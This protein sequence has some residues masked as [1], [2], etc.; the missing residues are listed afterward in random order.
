M[1]LGDASHTVYMID[2]GLAK[3]YFDRVAKRHIPF[4]SDKNLTGT[5]RYA[6]LSAHAGCEQSRR[7]DLEALGYVLVYLLRGALP[8]QG[9]EGKTK[10][11]KYARIHECKKTTPLQTLCEEL[12][13]AFCAYLQYVRSL[14]FEEVPDYSSLRRL[15]RDLWQER[16]LSD[17]GQPS[18]YD[19]DNLQKKEKEE[20]EEQEADHVDD[21]ED[22]DEGKQ[23]EQKE[24]DSVE[25]GTSTMSL[26]PSTPSSSVATSAPSV[27][28]SIPIASKF[29]RK[30]K[31]LKIL[32]FAV[33]AWPESF[34]PCAGKA[35]TIALQKTPKKSATA[36]IAST[37]C[38][39]AERATLLLQ[40]AT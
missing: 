24:E 20:K 25:Q 3:K 9:L 2:L 7:D 18:G 22:D 19:W 32:L 1:G 10:E 23:K 30:S 16:H 27:D 31:K 5:A 40:S 34:S 33:L 13:Q 12:P 17:E 4:R 37:S 28:P 38:R 39:A 36:Q 14:G 8:W 26:P 29:V 35:A 21:D 6:S 11:E 15:F